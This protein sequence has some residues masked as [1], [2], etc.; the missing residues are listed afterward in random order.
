MEM[1]NHSNE[2]GRVE[3]NDDSALAGVSPDGELH[4]V[5]LNG[6]DVLPFVETLLNLLI[7]YAVVPFKEEMEVGGSCVD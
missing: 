4:W 2:K 5:V 3:L 7:N 1:N 6:L